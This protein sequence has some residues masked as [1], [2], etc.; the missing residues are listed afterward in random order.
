M[1]F[2]GQT[3]GWLTTSWVLLTF[4]EQPVT[5]AYVPIIKAVISGIDIDFGFATIQRD[6][7]PSDLDLTDDSVLRGADEVNARSLN[8]SR[9][10]DAMLQLVPNV[11]TFRDTLRVIKLW[12]KRRGIYSNT[13]GFLGGVQW[14]ILVARVCQ[15]YPTA[16][17]SMLV[18]HFFVI[19]LRWNWPNP[20]MLRNFAS[21]SGITA[22]LT[23]KE[24][25]PQIY[26]AD[27]QHIMPILTPAYPSM[28]A[29]HNVS[30]STFKVMQREFQ[31]GYEVTDRILK[32]ESHDWKELFEEADFFSRYKWYLTVIASSDAEDR[33]HL[34]AG[35]VESKLR[36]LIVML[37]ENSPIINYAHPLIKPLSK[38]HYCLGEDEVREAAAGNAPTDDVRTAEEFEGKEEVSKVWTTTFF[39]G[40][41][42][43]K[44]KPQNGPRAQLDLSFPVAQFTR[45]VQS[46]NQ[47]DQPSM[48][49]AVRPLKRS[50]LPLQL[51]SDSE[52]AGTKKRRASNGSTAVKAVPLHENGIA[53]AEGPQKSFK[54]IK[55]HNDDIS[56]PPIDNLSVN[57]DSESA[58]PTPSSITNNMLPGP[59]P[60]EAEMASYASA[61][62]GLA[63]APN[64]DGK[65]VMQGS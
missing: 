23:F 44:S 57:G 43:V 11:E 16:L 14:A 24:W 65:L 6:K 42:I 19:L 5:E 52:S 37:E 45:I 4:I 31:R 54:R 28:C 62:A 2:S 51:R 3:D 20:A 22:S 40:L 21:R 41:D 56:T 39:I 49:V 10:T 18:R 30:Q 7:V 32:S 25:N 17:P 13:L 12:A 8:G 48:G 34:W 64:Q 61:A 27:R 47:Y 38:V 9:V 53:G 29:T 58:A 35:T 33:M 26:P 15:L 59:V 36:R 50:Q 1:N 55:S 46:W 63:P 60:T